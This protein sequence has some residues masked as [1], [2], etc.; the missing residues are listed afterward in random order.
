MNKTL[1]EERGVE[2]LKEISDRLGGWPIVVGDRWDERS[3]WSWIQS[4][5]DFRKAGYSMDYIF[6]FSVGIDLKNSTSRTID[7]S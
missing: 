6:D 4:V 7:V 1:I 3:S 5:K 2:P